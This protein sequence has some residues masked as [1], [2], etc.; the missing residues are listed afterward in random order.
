MKMALRFHPQ[1]ACRKLL[2]WLA[3]IALVTG[4]FPSACPADGDGWTVMVYLYGS[5]MEAN[6]GLARKDLDE[7]LSCVRDD[8][9]LLVLT[10][11]AESSTNGF[12][13]GTHGIYRVTRKEMRLLEANEQDMLG[14]EPLERLLQLG[15]AKARGKTALILWD[16]GFGA[17]EGFGFNTADPS[18][19]LT[20]SS[21]R[22]ALERG[23]AGKTLTLIGFDACFMADLETALA[24][25]PYAEYL[26]SS[27]ETEPEDGWD[28]SFLASL[29][30]DVSGEQAGKQIIDAYA[31]W[32]ESAY[33]LAPYLYQPTTLSLVRLAGTDALADALDRVFFD[34][35]ERV[36]GGGFS[37]V[38]RARSS[39]HAFGRG[40]TPS[41]YDLIDLGTL[42]ETFAEKGYPVSD[43]ISAL[44]GC[45][46]YRGGD[47]EEAKGLSLYFP[48]LSSRQNR[49]AW[50]QEW[51][52]LPI[53]EAWKAFLNRFEAGL[54]EKR[55]RRELL[56]AREGFSALLD[57]DLLNDYDHARYYILEE[58]PDGDMRLLY[59][60][61]D[62][63][64]KGSTVTANY[65]GQ[66]LML[67][68]DGGDALIP[69]FLR[70]DH[71][72]KADYQA[73]ML[74]PDSMTGIPKVIWL[75][76]QH[77]QDTQTWQVLSAIEN[78]DLSDGLVTGRQQLDLTKVNE[79]MAGSFLYTP[80]L[81]ASGQPV[82]YNHWK[83]VGWPDLFPVT[84]TGDF[85]LAEEPIPR[86][87]GYRYWLQ[88][89]VVD[90]YRQE[91]T[92]PL[93][94]L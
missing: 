76:I 88:L 24:V 7:M 27:Q 83:A 43:A 41:E 87:D 34:L 74:L 6:K 21:L 47:V 36:A 66:C 52:T 89:E 38:S 26:L 17:L 22:T 4:T 40:T 13:P 30:A 79:V 10:G 82:S 29:S 18:R 68:T 37:P 32:Y 3:L 93:F 56:P 57:D 69:A 16:H 42:M 63:T 86:R 92:A 94:P 60:G 28:Y 33:R 64:L 84:F 49:A 71:G 2:L 25:R 73:V 45:V 35:D 77:D 78:D 8:T 23:L 48:L 5:T 19:H 14:G 91:H 50:R 75:R 9:T 11:G 62:C 54:D 90:T 12:M 58:N 65:R 59:A 51:S 81:S 39:A 20:L 15:M 80:V 85:S 53:G 31:A 44:K 55:G 72:K 46:V 61:N 1:K 70:Q 67:H